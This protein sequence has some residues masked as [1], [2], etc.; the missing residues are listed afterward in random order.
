MSNHVPETASARSFAE[1]RET[2]RDLAVRMEEARKEADRRL[3]EADR[4]REEADRR[5]EEADRRKEAEDR[6]K[7][8]E[9]RQRRAEDRR[10]RADE[11]RRRR[12]A[13]R[14]LQEID[15]LQ[16]ETA[17]Q[18]KE[19]DRRLKKAEGLFTTQW[20]KLLESL[21]EGDLVPLLKDWGIDVSMTYQRRT[22]RRNGEHVEFDIVASNGAETVVVEV[23]TT[24]RPE[25][26][27]EFLSK[28]SFFA[29]WLP[30]H[31]G[32]RIY[33]AVAYLKS[34]ES[35]TTY[36]ERQGLFV[37]RATGSSASIVNAADF[38]PRTFPSGA[39]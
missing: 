21:V 30:D 26:V 38:K 18:M 27:K 22:G 8:A 34:D 36:A 13:D 29:D 25:A 32:E 11:D 20:G 15:Q 16:K 12:E 9:D 31:R 39:S 1:I 19:T 28:L 6:R 4:R 35:V 37:I 24:L 5:R 14:R 23:K 10:R 33:G 3:K 17:L 2:L 7:E